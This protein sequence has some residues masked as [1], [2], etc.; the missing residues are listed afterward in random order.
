MATPPRPVHSVE[1]TAYDP[2]AVNSYMRSHQQNGMAYWN[3]VA[4]NYTVN[5]YNE[6]HTTWNGSDKVDL[7]FDAALEG[8]QKCYYDLTHCLTIPATPPGGRATLAHWYRFEDLN[9]AVVQW[10]LTDFQEGKYGTVEG[11]PLYDVLMRHELGHDHFL[12]DHG[13][14][15][16]EP[17]YAGLM[18]GF[19]GDTGTYCVSL[20][21]ATTQEATIASSEFT[22]RPQPPTT[23]S[24]GATTSNSVTVNFSGASGHDSFKP[25]RSTS[26]TNWDNP[27]TI[28]SGSTSYTFTG[29]SSNTTYNFRIAAAKSGW[30]EGTS[31]WVSATTQ[32]PSG[33]DLVITA[34]P[35][36]TTKNEGGTATFSVTVKNQGT[37]AAGPFAIN[38]KFNGA[39]RDYP[40]GVYAFNSGLAAGAQQAVTT[41][42][43]TM[44]FAGGT[45]VAVADYLVTP[46]NPNGQVVET[47]ESNNEKTGGT[48]GVKPKAPVKSAGDVVI[49]PPWN[50]YA[51]IDRSN[52][53]TGFTV[54]VQRASTSCSSWST[55]T[56]RT[57]GASSGTG[58]QV[59]DTY[60][61]SHGYCWR[62]QVRVNGQYANS[63][64]VTSDEYK[65][66]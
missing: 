40:Q 14:P 66:P 57:Y 58:K 26:L 22:G 9:V 45:M 4:W 27:A 30:E 29:L 32:P 65:Y 46:Q 10:N 62:F 56:T 44:D 36:S 61:M 28:G 37:A 54:K 34:A 43:V 35:G 21:S 19:I 2:V 52:I 15:N 7:I 23:I 41:L 64:Y 47:N 31:W 11:V 24:V 3:L 13:K 12:A 60:T 49:Y 55:R 53:E 16:P 6:T 59:N 20:S 1:Q 39:Y 63:S 42:P 25:Y 51:W 18:C 5:T 8:Q 48:L 50:L 17:T 33:A 38:I